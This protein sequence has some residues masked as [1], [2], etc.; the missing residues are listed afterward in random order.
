M[1]NT[2]LA[3]IFSMMALF[4]YMS[5]PCFAQ[6]SESV[7]SNVVEE[8]TD[9]RNKTETASEN[10]PGSEFVP[11]STKTYKIEVSYPTLGQNIDIP[12]SNYI[13]GIIERFK[14]DVKKNEVMPDMMDENSLVITYR[15]TASSAKATSITL[16]IFSALAGY[17]H[18]SLN[19]V[20]KTYATDTGAPLEFSDIFQKPEKAL[21]LLSEYCRSTL[22]K[23]LGA[24]ADTETIK[25]GTNPDYTNFS[26]IALT[27]E[28]LRVHFQPYQVGPWA[29]GP[30]V[31]DV[32]LKQLRTATPNVALWDKH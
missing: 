25:E 7:K 23:Q 2:Y 20:T 22:E 1:K 27:P 4:S 26:C 31:V 3:L 18:P 9:T 17:A 10:G 24:N 30:Q 28:G 32:P 12:L 13:T 6:T 16:D 15:L 21:E 8:Q 29:I 14:E 11:H 19:I 5:S